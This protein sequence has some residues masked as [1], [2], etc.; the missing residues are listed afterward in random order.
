MNSVS[1]F[2]INQQ[3]KLSE[4][5]EILVRIGRHVDHNI[6]DLR[7]RE[8]EISQLLD[9]L[10]SSQHFT[11]L[12]RVEN[13]KV[14]KYHDMEYIVTRHGETCVRYQHLASETKSVANLTLVSNLVQ[15]IT[16]PIEQFP[17]QKTYQDTVDQTTYYFRQ[18]DQLELR[19]TCEKG[20]TPCYWKVD[21]AVIKENIYH[22]RLAKNLENIVDLLDHGLTGKTL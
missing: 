5:A 7:F 15:R 3:A 10:K 12:Y 1:H 6:T 8:Q 17:T 4:T 20:S 9:S 2:V 14:Y 21:L 16:S 11:N 18:D 13:R 19:L 22:D